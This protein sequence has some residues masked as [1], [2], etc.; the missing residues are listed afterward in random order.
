MND[1]R[2]GYGV[3][4]AVQPPG[5]MEGER[6]I[7]YLG[8]WEHDCFH[9]K[10]RLLVYESKYKRIKFEEHDGSFVAGMRDG[11]GKSLKLKDAEMYGDE[12]DFRKE[13]LAATVLEYMD[14]I[15]DFYNDKPVYHSGVLKAV[16]IPV[17]Q[18]VPDKSR[19]PYPIKSLLSISNNVNAS[20]TRLQ[21]YQQ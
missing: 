10:G 16:K 5:D 15:G 12:E 11:L 20:S 18:L 7:E 4:K 8:N 1:L 21:H 3:L 13:V 14:F 6:Y 2:H 19:D 9:G 17:S